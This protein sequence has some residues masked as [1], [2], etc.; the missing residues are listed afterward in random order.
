MNKRYKKGLTLAELL[1][2]AAILVFVFC[3]LLGLFINCMFLNRTNRNR[4]QATMHAQYILE[5]IRDTNFSNLQ[6]AINMGVWSWSTPATWQANCITINMDPL[7]DETVVTSIRP[8]S[9]NDPLEVQVRVDWVDSQARPMFL[10]LE[11][12]FTD[13]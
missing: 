9:P 8:G 12:K 3:G 1:I 11:T 6:N 5:E 4:S 13:Y 10:Q 2:S 7:S